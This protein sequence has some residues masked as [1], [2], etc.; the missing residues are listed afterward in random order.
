MTFPGSLLDQFAAKRGY[1]RVPLQL[2][3]A[4]TTA[5]RH[6][7]PMNRGSLYAL[8]LAGV[9]LRAWI[10]GAFLSEEEVAA[11]WR[12]AAFLHIQGLERAR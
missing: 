3:E 7:A 10:E 12:L 9:D 8:G 11:A 4:N 5:G 1:R 2:D 6:S